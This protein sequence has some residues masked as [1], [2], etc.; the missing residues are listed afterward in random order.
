MHFDSH[1]R[2]QD[3]SAQ[4]S[5]RNGHLQDASTEPTLDEDFDTEVLGG[6]EYVMTTTERYELI[7][8][9]K[10]STHPAYSKLD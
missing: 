6:S 10:Y 8:N 3:N 1:K 2:K 9:R 5:N 7:K 4:D